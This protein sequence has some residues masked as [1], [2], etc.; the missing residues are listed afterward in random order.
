[1]GNFDFEAGKRLRREGEIVDALRCLKS[2]LEQERDDVEIYVEL[3]Q[4]YLLAFDES[5]DPLCLD[6]AR[7]VC[8]AGLRREPT[9]EERHTLLEIQDGVENLLMESQKAEMDAMTDAMKDGALDS[10]SV[11]DPPG[12][13]DFLSDLDDELAEE[14]EGERGH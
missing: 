10:G 8:L 11:V 3:A 6:S 14:P 13:P 2:A 4:T 1:M 5:G 9:E 12:A 7:K